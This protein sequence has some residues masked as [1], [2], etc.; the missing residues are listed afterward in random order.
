M[1]GPAPK[2]ERRRRNTPARGEWQPTPDI[3]WQHGPTPKPPA[4]LTTVAR[5]TWRIWFGSWWAAHW[6]PENLPQIRTAIKLFDAYE[7]GDAKSV[8][9]LRQWMDGIGVTPYGQQKLRW[10][11]PAA[12]P[13]P[14]VSGQPGHYRHLKAV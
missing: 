7:R 12:E 8:T 11:P 4:G 9:E 14:D 3:G 1:P 10:L 5:E 2:V 6:T 13:V